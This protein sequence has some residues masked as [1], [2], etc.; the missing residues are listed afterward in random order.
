M[1]ARQ[2]TTVKGAAGESMAAAFLESR[3]WSVL[4]RNFRCPFGEIDLITRQ[5]DVVAF[6]EV[7]SW[8]SVPL[9]DL[10]IS[11]GPRKRQ[12]IARAA[13]RFLQGRPDLQGVHVRFD[14]VFIGGAEGIRHIPE[15]F[16]GEG[17]D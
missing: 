8:Q 16:T 5:K 2:S 10:G 1:R 15:A 3:G 13:R 7:K 11:V 12:R 6:V 14:V 17:I 4:E 9:E